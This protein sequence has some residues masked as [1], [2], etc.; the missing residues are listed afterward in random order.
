MES[1]Q[2]WLNSEPITRFMIYFLHILWDTINI[3]ETFSYNFHCLPVAAPLLISPYI[4]EEVSVSHRGDSR[5][6]VVVPT[7]TR[8]K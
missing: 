7:P 4:Y 5:L 1:S 6:Y 2:F 3:L 8:T